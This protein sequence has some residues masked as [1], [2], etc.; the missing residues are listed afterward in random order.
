MSNYQNN[1]LINLENLKVRVYRYCNYRSDK[2]E[3]DGYFDSKVFAAK[4]ESDMFLVYDDC[5]NSNDPDNC[6]GFKWV[7]FSEQMISY[8][9]A[10]LED[11]YQRFEPVVRLLPEN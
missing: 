3:Y 1:C 7:H 10:M 5:S 11:K 2:P 6:G 9:T 4:L 8:D